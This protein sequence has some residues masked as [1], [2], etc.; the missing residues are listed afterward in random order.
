MISGGMRGQLETTSLTFWL[1]LVSVAMM[2][3]AF[4]YAVL[5]IWMPIKPWLARYR[6]AQAWRE[7][8]L[9]ELPTLLALVPVLVSAL[10]ILREAWQDIKGMKSEGELNVANF[11]KVA[12]KFAENAEGLTRDPALR[13]AKNALDGVPGSRSDDKHD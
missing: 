4:L 12:R 11:S 10:N 13:N 1:L 9:L 3:G 2:Y 7:W 8:I 6:R 5:S